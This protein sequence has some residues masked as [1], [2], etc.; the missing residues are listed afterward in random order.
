MAQAKVTAKLQ[1]D[2]Q[3]IM[4]RKFIFDSNRSLFM[5]IANKNYMA[6]LKANEN[7][8]EVYNQMM[9]T[10]KSKFLDVAKF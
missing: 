2:A 9:K 1:R 5:D 6:D 7:E 10:S 3:A 4:D 8:M